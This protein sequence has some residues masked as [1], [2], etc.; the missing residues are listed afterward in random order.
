MKPSAYFFRA[1]MCMVMACALV[2]RAGMGAASA[3]APPNLRLDVSPTLVDVGSNVGFAL[4]ASSWPGP[5]SA[6]LAFVSPHHGFS[7]SMT[8]VP[9]CGCFE[10]AVH[11]APRIHALEQARVAATVKSAGTTAV[12]RSTFSIRGLSSNGRTL[13][14]GGAPTLHGWVS[15]PAPTAQEIE[16]FCAWATT[17]DGLGVAG[18]RVRFRVHF[19]S[20]VQT[21]SP[22]STPASGLLCSNRSIGA[23][24]PGRAVKVEI[25]AGSLT[26]TTS[27]TPRA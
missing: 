19:G 15:D 4:S 7:G 16:H 1:S 24:T 23:A 11:L 6:T 26:T 25:F 2:A 22:G 13:S 14:P 27:F 21:W 20:K 12:V 17:A 18:L 8:W 5:A 10:I 9:Q 3:A